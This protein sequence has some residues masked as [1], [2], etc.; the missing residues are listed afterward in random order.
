MLCAKLVPPAQPDDYEA[1]AYRLWAL[2]A[3]RATPTTLFERE[4]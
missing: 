2:K 1:E 3:K 4:R